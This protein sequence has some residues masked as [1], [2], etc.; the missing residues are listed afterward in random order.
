MPTCVRTLHIV[1]LLLYCASASAQ[2]MPPGPRTFSIRESEPRIGTNL[3]GRVATGELPFDKR[4]S[5]LTQDQ[6][7]KFKAQYQSMADDDE[8][9]FPIDGLASLYKPIVQAQ[10]SLLLDG[11]LEMEVEVD[12]TGRAKSV[13][14]RKSPSAEM[15]QVA[16]AALMFQAYKPAVCRGNPCAMVFPLRV[17]L[18]R[19]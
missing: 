9:P 8:P 1:A 2:Y 10:Q 13:S 16:A 11:P 14:V 18:I 5:E 12:A 17:D 15:T 4:Y 19:R 6:K 3:Q 7:N